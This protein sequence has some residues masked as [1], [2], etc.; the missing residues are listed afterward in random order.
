MAIGFRFLGFAAALTA[1]GA[2]APLAGCTS[3]DDDDD[4]SSNAAGTASSA[5]TTASAGTSNGAGS[6]AGG[7][8]SGGSATGAG[9]VCASPVVVK[10]DAPGIA[11]F[12][13]Y[14]G[15]TALS[16]WN[17]PLG[18]DKAS[19]V[20]AGP[21]GY[22][23]RENNAPET[24]E[25]AEGNDSK[26]S[27]RI[28]DTMAEKFGGGEGLWL[29]ACLDATAL[30]GISFWVRG[31]APKG[32]SV[33]TLSM[34]ETTPSTPAKAG[35]KTGSCKGDA[36]TCIGPKFTFPVTDAWTEVKVAWA[37][38]NPGDAAGGGVTP[39]GRNITQ[40]QF[41][42]ELNWVPDDAGVYAPVAAPYELAVDSL[43]FY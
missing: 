30:H 15:A 32:E 13:N 37:D 40:V 6:A 18:G 43:S 16:M 23:D 38:F 12:D 3:G 8:S 17:F 14:D 22:G 5:G 36:M 28:A 25:M 21:F 11:D 1:L 20:L 35:D 42:V 29:S 31:N 26:Y 10:A 7:S 34:G 41:G 9:T 4:S 39:D 24:F 33:M 19:S 2:S 27:L